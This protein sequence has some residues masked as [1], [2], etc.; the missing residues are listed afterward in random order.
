MVTMAPA[1]SVAATEDRFG[2]DE[3]GVG[4]WVTSDTPRNKTTDGL[5]APRS[6]SIIGKFYMAAAGSVSAVVT[7]LCS[8]SAI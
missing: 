7:T 8:V 2:G 1:S 4:V 3:V 6:A 5:E